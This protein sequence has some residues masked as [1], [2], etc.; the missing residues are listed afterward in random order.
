MKDARLGKQI[1]LAQVE[2]VV[3]KMIEWC[4]IIGQVLQIENTSD[5]DFE[6]NL[7]VERDIFWQ[8]YRGA[9][10][11]L[12][13]HLSNRCTGATG[14]RPASLTVIPPYL[15]FQL[16]YV[17]SL[18][19]CLRHKS[20][21]FVPASASCNI[22]MICSP[23]NLFF[24]RASFRVFFILHSNYSWHNLRGV[25]PNQGRVRGNNSAWLVWHNVRNMVR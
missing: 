16:Q 15:A 10:Y 3:D 9:V 24:I 6:K 13:R 20:I 2:D 8:E 5:R 11:L 7:W 21:I 25:F 17:A 18:I 14:Q 12:C 19:P 4:V 22:R 1:E 23:V